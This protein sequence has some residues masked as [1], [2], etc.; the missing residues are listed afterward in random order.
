MHSGNIPYTGNFWRPLNLVK[1]PEMAWY[2]IWRILNLAIDRKNNAHRDHVSRE[3][4]RR[5]RRD[6]YTMIEKPQPK[7]EDV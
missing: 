1:S 2:K 6:L 5:G 3:R 7:D 4:A